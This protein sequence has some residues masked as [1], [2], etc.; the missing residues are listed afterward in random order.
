MIRLRS[1]RPPLGRIQVCPVTPPA[2]D[3]QHPRAFGSSERDIEQLDR[4]VSGDQA[5]FLS[6]CCI[7]TPSSSRISSVALAKSALGNSVGKNR[8]CSPF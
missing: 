5:L 2:H 1:E 8:S 3:L 6:L 4:L 7:L